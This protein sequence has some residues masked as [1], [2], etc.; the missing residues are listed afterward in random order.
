VRDV[1]PSLHPVGTAGRFHLDAQQVEAF[2][3]AEVG[4]PGDWPRSMIGAHDEESLIEQQV[5]RP[6]MAIR[7]LGKFWCNQRQLRT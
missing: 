7:H 1:E 2:A 4:M 6:W 5:D 3:L